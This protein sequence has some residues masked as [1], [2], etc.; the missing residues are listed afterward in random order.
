MED[1]CYVP[2]PVQISVPT[3]LDLEIILI[4]YLQFD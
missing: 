1:T 2:N 4:I 3:S